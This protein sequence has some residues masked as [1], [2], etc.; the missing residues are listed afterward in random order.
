MELQI[1][2]PDKVPKSTLISMVLVNFIVLNNK[3]SG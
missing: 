2:K 1:C 3:T